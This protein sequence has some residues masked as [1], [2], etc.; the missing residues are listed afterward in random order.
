MST[1]HTRWTDQDLL[2]VMRQ[3]APLELHAYGF[4]RVQVRDRKWLLSLDSMPV[5]RRCLD[6]YARSG[7]TKRAMVNAY[8]V[9]HKIE[10]RAE[11]L[12]YVPE[13]A[14]ILAALVADMP[15]RRTAYG[16]YI[17]VPRRAI[18]S[19]EAMP[20]PGAWMDAPVLTMSTEQEAP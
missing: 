19:L 7:R 8:H 15:V 13:G 10:E 6:Y 17:G 18:R 2:F 9:K 20:L 4:G 5:I 11:P 16:T 1:D 3:V 14:A 12:L